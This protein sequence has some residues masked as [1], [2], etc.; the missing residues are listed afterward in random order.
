MPEQIED[1]REWIAAQAQEFCDKLGLPPAEVIFEEHPIFPDQLAIWRDPPEFRKFRIVRSVRTEIHVSPAALQ[2]QDPEELRY[3]VAQCL[4]GTR[5]RLP[6]RFSMTI[7]VAEMILPVAGIAATLI[8]LGVSPWIAVPVGVSWLWL[9][10]YIPMIGVVR[11]SRNSALALLSLG[12]SKE[13]A[14]LAAKRDGETKWGQGSQ[15]GTKMGGRIKRLS[16]KHIQWLT[17]L[18]PQRFKT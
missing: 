18:A 8:L 13:G 9:L 16:D 6:I 4:R 3:R 1:R 14:I 10:P 11:R 12:C 15:V 2:E 5:R 7:L 17:D